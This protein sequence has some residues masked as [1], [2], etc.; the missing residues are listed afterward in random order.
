MKA[1]YSDF[2]A[3]AIEDYPDLTVQLAINN[4]LERKNVYLKATLLAE[5]IG[6]SERTIRRKLQTNIHMRAAG[7]P[8]GPRKTLLYPFWVIH[9]LYHRDVGVGEVDDENEDR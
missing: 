3:K 2:L 1:Y 8:V 7:L 4:L 5:F 9:E 6:C